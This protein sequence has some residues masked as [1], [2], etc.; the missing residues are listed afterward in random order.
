MISGGGKGPLS[1]GKRNAR[2]F[3]DGVGAGGGSAVKTKGPMDRYITRESVNA[4]MLT[5]STSTPTVGN[6]ID[7]V[8]AKRTSEEILATKS[9]ASSDVSWNNRMSSPVATMSEPNSM[10]PGT[11]SNTNKSRRFNRVQH[12]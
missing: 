11:N 6:Q 10:R 2:T 1:T 12:Y 7:A 8:Q 9:E 4:H 3:G 5:T